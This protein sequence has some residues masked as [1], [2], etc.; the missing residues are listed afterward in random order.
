MS[1]VNKTRTS[2]R[3]PTESGHQNFMGGVS[4]TPSNPLVLLRMAAASTFFGEPTYYADGVARGTLPLPAQAL[5][6]ATQTHLRQTLQQV[7]PADWSQLG[8][9]ALMEQAI[10]AALAFDAEGTLQLAVALRQEDLI[11][12]TPQVIMVRAAHHAAVRGRGLIR[13]Y[14]PAIL[15][16]ADEPATQLAYHNSTYG[17]QT[18][19]PNALKK[20]WRNYLGTL[21]A[22]AVAKY[23]QASRVT[24]LVDVVNMCR[25]KSAVIDKLMKGTLGVSQATWESLVSA[26]GSTK[27]AWAEALEKFLMNPKGHMAL[28]RN[29]RNLHQHGLLSP[30]A[31]EALIDGAP[32]GKQLPFRYYAAYRELEAASASGPV[33]DA[34]E[35]CLKQSL[36][37]LPTF[38]GKVMSLVD[39]SG[40]AQGATTSAMGT[41]KVSTIGNLSGILTGMAADEGWLGVFG[42]KL[43]RIPVRKSASV[44]DQVNTA[45][46]AAETIGGDTENGIW[47]FFKEALAKKEHWDHIFVYS[48]MQAGHG[49]L[50]GLEPGDYAQYTF[51]G[52][53]HYID[54]ARLVRAYREQVNPKVMVYLVQTAGYK[55]TLVPEFYD[56]TFIL[57]GWGP[58]ILK[59]AHVM[60]SLATRPAQ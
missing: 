40:S 20:A 12:V 50:F 14:A 3:A 8:P 25:P 28:L 23:Q 44:F 5:T 4:Y 6:P 19:V 21:S 22:Y 35:A 51:P 57:G 43:T 54:V 56:R 17:K 33:L 9:V 7:T 26:Q 55:D 37:N 15:Q 60:Q 42:N 47:L 32:T 49:G 59:F 46:Y 2:V 27:E 29:L 34:V 11:R 58:G 45:E 10:D 24:K 1:T 39:N 41:M 13:Q 36:G 48:D 16:R 38:Q 31:L 53:A 30:R 52:K 18:P